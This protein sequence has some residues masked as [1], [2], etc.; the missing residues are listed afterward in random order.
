MGLV[1]M[2][3]ALIGGLIAG[4]IFGGIYTAHKSNKTLTPINLVCLY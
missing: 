3:M 2:A 4:L 1:A